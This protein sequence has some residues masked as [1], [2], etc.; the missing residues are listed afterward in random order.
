[1]ITESRRVSLQNH[2]TL[3]GRI[4]LG[5]LFF[6]SGIFM[7]KSGISGVAGMIEGMGIPL[8][9]LIAILVVAVK[10]LGGAGLILGYKT[11]ESALALFIFTF[12]TVVLVHNNAAEMTS[13]L[14]NISIMGGL[15]YVLAYG[16]GSGWKLG[17]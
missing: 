7:L 2:G 6:I 4:F 3:V 1:M 8:A 12:L 5:L 14:K 10:I 15:L 13:A 16:P 11:D 17:K 9:G